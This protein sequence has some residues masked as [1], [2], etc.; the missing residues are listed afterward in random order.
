MAW[1]SVVIPL[2]LL[3]IACVEPASPRPGA[4]ATAGAPPPM[5][6]T[7]SM[8]SRELP[9]EARAK[10]ANPVPT[11]KAPPK[12]SLRVGAARAA[13][14]LYADDESG[15]LAALAGCRGKLE[16]D[17]VRCLLAARYADDAKAAGLARDLYDRVE[18][19][20]GLEPARRSEFG[21]RGEIQLVPER[22]VGRYREHLRW[23]LSAFSDID[24]VY[25]TLEK[26]AARPMKYRWKGLELRFFRSVNRTT[27]AAFASAWYVGYNVSGSLMRSA[28]GVRDTLVHELFHMNDSDHAW[29]SGQALQ[30]TYGGILARCPIPRG[31]K[32]P[33][34]RCLRPWAPA[35]TTVKGGTYYA[36][37]PGN[38]VHEYAAELGLRYFLEQR[39]ALAGRR[40]PAPF[41]CGN[42]VNA[43]A[44]ALLVAE[45]HAGA[46]AVPACPSPPR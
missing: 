33:T 30:A 3:L 45:F 46:D 39:E 38:D 31:G 5:K 26:R 32:W 9:A 37:Q 2:L 28:E 18:V 21:Y 43:A 25:S 27:P 19:V 44:W 14:I 35:A 41:K 29:W 1:K 11:A 8:P 6:I 20:A 36:F 17:L 4:G 13:E 34:R 16:Q 10:S 12:S 23:V 15:R 42:A 40:I 22:P 24:E 7:A